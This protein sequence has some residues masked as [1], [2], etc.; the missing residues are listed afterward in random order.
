MLYLDKKHDPSMNSM[1][2]SEIMGKKQNVSLMAEE[3]DRLFQQYCMNHPDD[4][5]QGK[6]ASSLKELVTKVFRF[7]FAMPARA[8][9]CPFQ[10][11]VEEDGNVYPEWKKQS[12]E[13]YDQLVRMIKKEVNIEEYGAVGD[14]KTDNTDAF[15]KAFGSG[16]VKVCVPA[17]VFL[18][19]EIKLPSWT[20]L[21]GEGKGLTTIKLHNDAPIATR[22]L[23]N[24]NH[25]RGNHHIFIREMSLDWNV[26]RLGSV[27]KTSTWGNHSSCLTFAHVSYGWVKEVEAI[28]PGLHCF[29]ITSTLYN[30]SGDGYRA[31]RGSKYIWLDRLN[32]YGFGDD[33]ITTHHS[34]NVF[35]SNSHMC[36]PSGRSHQRGNSNSNGIEIDD[37][38]Q[39]IMLVNN[40]T[41][42][43]FGGVEIKA[44]EN[45]SA[46]S[47]VQI[48]GHL[49]VNDNR[50]Y[51]FRHIGHHKSA[52][53]ESKTAYTI[54]AMN[55]VA[56]GPVFSELYQESSPRAL[57]VS[58]YKNVVINNFTIIGDSEYD[59]KDNPVVA[60]QYRARNVVL[61]NIAIKHFKNAGVDIKV[62][63]GKQRAD[64][65]FISNAIINHS[66]RQG[67]DIGQG[68]Q[69]SKISHVRALG[70]GGTVGLKSSAQHVDISDFQ[71]EGYAAVVLF[72]G[73]V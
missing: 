55:I 11:Y 25:W 24:A 42:R 15:K 67:I 9:I 61:N 70:D 7:P 69:R 12:D 40:S 49:S 41:T 26:E 36:D 68:I 71:A 2:I 28:N 51:N 58:A 5:D 46:A 52:D 19:K 72:T 43:C 16:R 1:L 66:A 14:G 62:F 29:D 21:V 23:T 32:G 54:K 35:I 65:I 59:Y 4:T 48:V 8:N 57:V 31:R 64:H 22:L 45:S 73:K 44:H 38:S 37:G 47:N 39:N 3:T 13:Q 63:G 34:D 56:I 6:R 17:G 10:T 20:C 33:G 30:Y 18:T 50:A 53:T 60:I 27:E